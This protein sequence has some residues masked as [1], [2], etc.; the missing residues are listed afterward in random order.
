ML[1]TGALAS[2]SHFMRMPLTVPLKPQL[3]TVKFVMPSVTVLPME[4][5]C[6]L[7]KTQLLMTKPLSGPVDPRAMLSS[8][9]LMLQFTI[10]QFVPTKSM[11][12]VLGEVEAA[13]SVRL[14]M[15]MLPPVSRI[16]QWW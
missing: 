1:V 4:T 8:P 6:P 12:S 15:V 7:P 16:P 10:K 13:V 3:M 5:P 9:T 2:G 14:L 11:P